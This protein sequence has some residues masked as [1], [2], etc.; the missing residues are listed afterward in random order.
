MDHYRIGDRVFL[1]G[2][3]RGAHTVR[4]LADMLY[5]CGLLWQGN[6]NLIPYMTE[7]YY[8]KRTEAQNFKKAF[9]RGCP[10]H[11]I[12][13]WDTVASVGWIH[14]KQ[15]SNNI[16]NPQVKFAYQ[17]LAINER[18]HFFRPS[19]WSESDAYAEQSIEQVWFAGGHEDVGGQGADRGT[20]DISLDWMLSHAQ[21]RGLCL[22]EDWRSDLSPDPIARVK[23]SDRWFWR[24]FVCSWRPRDRDIRDGAKIHESAQVRWMNLG[25]APANVPRKFRVVRTP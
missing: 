17:A 25:D 13:V 4:T 12:G 15:F 9:S 7:M 5:R 2:Y 19:V 6:E 22:R 10:I 14:R 21:N 23:K 11:L 8:T 24:L 18:R 1:F 16:L 3:S 20:S